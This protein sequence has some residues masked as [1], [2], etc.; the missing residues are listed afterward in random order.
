M[1]G[2][3]LVTILAGW[4][5]LS[6]GYRP[7]LTGPK[8]SGPGYAKSQVIVDRS[9]SWLFENGPK[10]PDRTGPEGAS[11]KGAVQSVPIYGGVVDAFH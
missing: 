3:K 11:T 10:K 1:T 4:N 2:F 5:R 9:R 7:R 6:E 8:Q